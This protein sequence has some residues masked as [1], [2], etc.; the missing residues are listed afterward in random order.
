[1][2]YQQYSSQD[3]TSGERQVNRIISTLVRQAGRHAQK[4][5]LSFVLALASIVSAPAAAQT[6]IPDPDAP[7]AA[8]AQECAEVRVDGE[9]LFRVRG[10]TAYPADRICGDV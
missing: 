3:R 2:P 8:F 9:T 1:L 7:E 6:G 4:A 10:L 5:V